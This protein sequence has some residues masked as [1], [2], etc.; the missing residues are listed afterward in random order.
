MHRNRS[1]PR[2]EGL[3]VA[4]GTPG[5]PVAFP[6]V[7]KRIM[8]ALKTDLETNRLPEEGTKLAVLVLPD[9]DTGIV[10]IGMAHPLL[11]GEC[12]IGYIHIADL[13][14]LMGREFQRLGEQT[15]KQIAAA[16]KAEAG[17]TLA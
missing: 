10:R 14:V 13:Y 9:P 15:L 16:A 6:E 8:A 12:T 17:G 2:P 1:N 4:G 11:V 5:K 7:Y 3:P